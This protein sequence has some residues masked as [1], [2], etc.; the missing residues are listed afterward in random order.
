MSIASSLI[1][2]TPV[3]KGHHL[4]V[5][6]SFAIYALKQLHFAGTDVLHTLLLRQ[7]VEEFKTKTHYS[8]FKVYK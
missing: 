1:H 2:V 3:G 7:P 4:D 6:M 5:Q 8:N